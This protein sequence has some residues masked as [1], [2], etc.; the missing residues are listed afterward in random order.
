MRRIL[1]TSLDAGVAALILLP[2]FL[3]LD[4]KYVRN[5]TRSAWYFLFAVY[6]AGVYA[7]VGLPNVRYVRLD[8][9]VNVVPFAYMFS[10]FTNSLLNVILFVPLGFLLPVLWE[11]YGSGCRTVL[12]GFTLS[13]VIEILQIFTFRATDVNDLMTN[14][15]GTLL[16]FGLGKLF[17][18]FQ[19][20]LASAG[21]AKDVHIV[22]GLSWGVM[23]FLQPFLAEE[24][25]TFLY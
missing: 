7:V 10:D 17:A 18:R 5:H 21:D 20:G 13:L 2:L 19:P 9:N 14:T 16:G 23:F 15:L 22:W 24:G 25:W 8:L 3:L 1:L 12:F 11:R 6:L 4:R